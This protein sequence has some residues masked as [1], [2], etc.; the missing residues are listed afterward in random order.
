MRSVREFLKQFPLAIHL[1]RFINAIWLEDLNQGYKLSYSY[2]YLC[3][4]LWQKPR[5]QNR[6]VRLLNGMKTRVYWDSDAGVSHLFTHNVDFYESL[7]IRKFLKPG[8]FV[9]DAGCNVGNRTLALA[10]IIS[11]ALMIDANPICIER[12]QENFQ[13]NRIDLSAYHLLAKAVGAQPGWVHFSDQGASSCQNHIILEKP[14]EAK[15]RRVEMVTL[16]GAMATIGQT[17]CRFIKLDLEGFDLD[18]LQGA[19]Q[20][21]ENAGVALVEFERWKHLPLESFIAFFSDLDWQVLC[22]DRKGRT[23]QQSHELSQARNLFALSPQAWKQ[24]SLS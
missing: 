4:Y 20:T 17:H 19:R 24:I 5:K 7:F 13:I 23:T 21:L 2:K 6:R 18:G 22:L 16:D 1:Y 12:L 10:D 8:D 11:G 15:T 9:I 3:W 14:A